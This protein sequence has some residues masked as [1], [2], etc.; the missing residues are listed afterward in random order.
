MNSVDRSMWQALRGPIPLN[1]PYIPLPMMIIGSFL[2][3]FSLALLFHAPGELGVLEVTLHAALPELP[4][5][6][7]LAALIIF[8]GLPAAALRHRD[9]GGARLRGRPDE[10][11]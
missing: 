6:D 3:S 10:H 11:R 7:V 4:T 5:V 9:A 2:A 1:K 8:R